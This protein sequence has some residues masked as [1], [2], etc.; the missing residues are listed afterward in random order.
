NI[1]KK[2]IFILMFFFLIFLFA[3]NL[4]ST[5]IS[6]C[7]NLGTGTYNLTQNLAING[8]NCLNITGNNVF[9]DC[10]NYNIS[11]N[12]SGSGIYVSGATANIKNCNIYNFSSGIYIL[13]SSNHIINSVILNYN[14]YGL[15]VDTSNSNNFTSITT[16]Y[17]T[18]GI[19]LDT[20][21][22]NNLSS[23]TS[24][25][26]EYYGFYIYHSD[27]NNL[28]LVTANNNV[29]GNIVSFNYNNNIQDSKI[30]T[31]NFGFN[32][33][34]C[35]NTLKNVSDE[36]N[37]YHY[38]FNNEN[39]ISIDGWTNVSSITLCNTNT[40]EF[41]NM[42]GSGFGSGSFVYS[43]FSNN[44]LFENLNLTNF[45]IAIGLQ[46]SDRNNF[47]NIIVNRN[48]V[49]F[50]IGSSSYN[51]FNSCTIQDNNGDGI[52][53]TWSHYNNFTNMIITDNGGNGMYYVFYSN[54]NIIKNSNISGN[55]GYNL[56][57]YDS[58][59]SGN[60]NLIYNNTL[61]N[62]SK[63]YSNNW[64]DWRISFNYS[65]LGNIYYN[66]SGFGNTSF[67]FDSPANYSCDNFATI[68]AF[69]VVVIGSSNS[70]SSLFP[71]GFESF[72]LSLILILS[73]YFI[74]N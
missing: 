15:N 48:N 18:Y 40:S 5:D 73:S 6:S 55:T 31:F 25:Y 60:G 42:E 64:N 35:S 11:G 16:N 19:N 4:F 26:N 70:I 20:T 61:G 68:I 41:K 22:Y 9:L 10:Q 23:I 29:F 43:T 52:Q 3:N 56:N 74:F 34:Q 62:I 14:F 59:G 57:F 54:Y 28:S 13:S 1:K 33:L 45:T 49:G 44:N 17:N 8:T 50:D 37:K 21:D 27:Y 51:N 32:N 39:G 63:I 12:S 69:P 47:T 36:N 66:Y 58:S 53:P 38:I 24:T 46:N 71:F 2:I 7:Q 67:C 30:N 65:N 72:F